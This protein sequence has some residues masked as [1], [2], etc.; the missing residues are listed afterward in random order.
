MGAVINYMSCHD[1]LTLWDKLAL[2]NPDNTVE[3]RLAMNRMGITIIMIS[4]GTPFFLAGEEMLRSKDGDENSYASSDA[5][6][7]MRW[8]E[9]VPGSDAYKMMEYYKG[10]IEMRN[11]YDIFSAE[12]GVKI[13]FGA[14]DAGSLVVTYTA[15]NGKQALAV[16]NP[17]NVDDSYAVEGDWNLVCDGVQAGSAVLEE[18]SGTVSVSAGGI[19][20]LVR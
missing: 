2:S 19:V 1:N 15:E 8:E 6:N 20:V 7:N 4:K 11:T 5:I 18:V 13:E 17:T 3:E 12:S 9:L 10:L 14:T 16:I